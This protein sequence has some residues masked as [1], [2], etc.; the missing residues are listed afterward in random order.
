LSHKSLEFSPHLVRSSGGPTIN[1]STQYRARFFCAKY[2]TF[3]CVFHSFY[4]FGIRAEDELKLSDDII[5]DN[6]TSA[7]DSRIW[8]LSPMRLGAAKTAREPAKSPADSILRTFP[9]ASEKENTR[10]DGSGYLSEKHSGTAHG[11]ALKSYMKH[12]A[13]TARLH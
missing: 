8:D 11:I 5:E 4:L 10:N 12:T 3:D 13:G 6:F 2:E 9:T 7:L 1:G